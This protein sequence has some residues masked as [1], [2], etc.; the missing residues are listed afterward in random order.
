MDYP[1]MKH[2]E[3][4]L[5]ETFNIKM[6]LKLQNGQLLLEGTFHKSILP[7]VEAFICGFMLGIEYKIQPTLRLHTG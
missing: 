2:L 6:E 4:T 7:R 5:S 1:T 3:H